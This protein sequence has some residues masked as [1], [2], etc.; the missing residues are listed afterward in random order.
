MEAGGIFSLTLPP[1][2][3]PDNPPSCTNILVSHDYCVAVLQLRP[4]DQFFK[5]SRATNT[6][7]WCCL[8]IFFQPSCSLKVRETEDI[9]K[10]NLWVLEIRGFLLSAAVSAHVRPAAERQ[11]SHCVTKRCLLIHFNGTLQKITNKKMQGCLCIFKFCWNTM[12]HMRSANQ[13]RASAH[14]SEDENA[15]FTVQSSRQTQDNV[16]VAMITSHFHCCIPPH[17][18]VVFGC[19]GPFPRHTFWHLSQQK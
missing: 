3:P 2:C 15:V 8:L 13:V 19:Y 18:D 7:K 14:S 6:R 16:T 9:A 17:S 4:L 10:L 5:I 1:T 11:H 12:Q